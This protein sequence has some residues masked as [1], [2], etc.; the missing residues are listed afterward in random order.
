MMRVGLHPNELRGGA[1]KGWES[2]LRSVA[3]GLNRLAWP[4]AFCEGAY[5]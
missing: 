2:A 3:V 4:G 5:L 1:W